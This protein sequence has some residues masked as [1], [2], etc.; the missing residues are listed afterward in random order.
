M[1]A[2]K[3]VLASALALGAAPVLAST[4]T[5]GGGFEIGY[6]AAYQ[7]AVADAGETCLAI[8]GQ[9]GPTVI[10]DDATYAGGGYYSVLVRRICFGV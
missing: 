8:G 6:P 3:F 7:A 10:V 9:P 1:K 4:F 2:M 5:E